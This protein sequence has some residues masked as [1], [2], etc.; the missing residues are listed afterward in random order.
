MSWFRKSSPNSERKAVAPRGVTDLPL[1]DGR[2]VK[3]LDSRFTPGG[4][5]GAMDILESTRWAAV[6][7][8]SEGHHIPWVEG[9]TCGWAETLEEASEQLRERL[10]PQARP[11]R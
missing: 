2:L 7:R 4:E 3:Y 10:E 6:L 11:N 1:R 9:H 5:M 8:T